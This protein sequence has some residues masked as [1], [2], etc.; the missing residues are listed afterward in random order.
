[1]AANKPVPS[2]SQRL[3][4][5]TEAA[6]ELSISAR[7]AWRLVSRGDLQKVQVGRAVR[8]TRESI[9]AFIAKGGAR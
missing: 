3:L 2:P 4:K 5:L 1:M 9:D 8:V 6:D 7:S